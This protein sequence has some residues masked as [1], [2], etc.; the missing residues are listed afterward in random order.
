MMERENGEKQG[1]GARR[2]DDTRE[3]GRTCIGEKEVGGG[4]KWRGGR[5]VREEGGGAKNEGR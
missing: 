3:K 2:E 1:G 5:E 4:E